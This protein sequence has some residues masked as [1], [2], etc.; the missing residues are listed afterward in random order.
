MSDRQRSLL[1][2]TSSKRGPRPG[3]PTRPMVCKGKCKSCGAYL[4][5]TGVCRFTGLPKNPEAF[6]STP[7][8][9]TRSPARALA[10]ARAAGLDAVAAVRDGRRCVVVKG[11][12][13]R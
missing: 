8:S 2:S 13:R 11:K 9:P 5:Q 1:P 4:K 10:V 6:C 7:V 3:R 12:G